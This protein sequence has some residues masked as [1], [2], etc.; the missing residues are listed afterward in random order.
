MPAL[1]LDIGNC[2]LVF[3]FG[4]KG[5]AEG[6]GVRGFVKGCARPFEVTGTGEEGSRNALEAENARGKAN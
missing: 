6:E 4:G 1:Q 3:G 2:R 5:V